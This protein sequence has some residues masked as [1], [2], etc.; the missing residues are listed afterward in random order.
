MAKKYK[1][2]AAAIRS[3]VIG[4]VKYFEGRLDFESRKSKKVI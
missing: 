4:K 2:A 1:S 3:W